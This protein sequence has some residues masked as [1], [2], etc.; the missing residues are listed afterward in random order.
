MGKAGIMNLIKKEPVLLP[1]WLT[2]VFILQC[3]AYGVAAG[4]ASVAFLVLVFDIINRSFVAM[5]NKHNDEGIDL[6]A[7]EESFDTYVDDTFTKIF[8]NISDDHK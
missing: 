6:E 5:E 2:A 8:G 1:M 4:F 7:P 3:A